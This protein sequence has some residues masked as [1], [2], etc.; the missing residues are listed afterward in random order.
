MILGFKGRCPTIRRSRIKSKNYTTQIIHTP[1]CYYLSMAIFRK[2]KEKVSPPLNLYMPKKNKPAKIT[3]KK[4][5]RIFFLPERNKSRIKSKKRKNNTTI[6]PK[7]TK[8]L[9]FLLIP[10]FIAGLVFV[11]VKVVSKLREDNVEY[12]KENVVGLQNIPSYPSST[13]MF[14]NNMG[15][16]YVSTFI[17]SG[18]SAYKIQNGESIDDVYAFY[19]EELPKIGWTYIQTVPIGSEEMKDG[20]YWQNDTQ[21]LRIYSKHKDI[22]YESIS[23]EEAQN[24][25]KNRVEEKISRDLLLKEEDTQDLLPDFPWLIKIP[26]EYLISYRSSNFESNRSVEFKKLGSTESIN[27]VPIGKYNGGALDTYL[28]QYMQEIETEEKCIISKTYLSSTPYSSALKGTISCN[29][30]T[31]TCLVLINST[32]NIV[33]VIDSNSGETEFYKYVVENL[34]PQGSL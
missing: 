32:K 31:H 21:G 33:Y 34:T 23:I 8:F 1:I 17:S 29:V 25:L 6:L 22:W 10:I 27:I 13:F 19:K 24:G 20:M 30:E 9:L 16:P 11:L 4:N 12:K 5:K 14:E 26:K 28:R 15:D 2:K 3:R 7:I 18:N